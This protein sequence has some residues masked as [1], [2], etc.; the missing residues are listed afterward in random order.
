[1]SIIPKKSF[2]GILKQKLV[3]KGSKSEHQA[4][5]LELADGTDLRLRMLGENPF[6]N[7][8]LKPYV[9]KRVQ[10]SGF[11]TPVRPLLVIDSVADITVLGPPGKPAK[12]PQP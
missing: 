7:T 8:A 9:G 3:N 6:E 10:I 1:M 2:T 12:P 11:T 5:V 4:I